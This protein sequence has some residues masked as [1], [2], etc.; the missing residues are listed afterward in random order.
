M[1]ILCRR[2]YIKATYRPRAEEGGELEQCVPGS[3]A[4][5][6]NAMTREQ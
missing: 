6:A 3:A 1:T 5:T 4:P 2:R